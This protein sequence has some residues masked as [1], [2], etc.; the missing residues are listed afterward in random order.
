MCSLTPLSHNKDCAEIMGHRYWKNESFVLVRLTPASAEQ[1][2]T[3]LWDL[4]VSGNLQLNLQVYRFSPSVDFPAIRFP[5]YSP[6]L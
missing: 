5:Q 3:P 1:M 6:K 4:L 2:L